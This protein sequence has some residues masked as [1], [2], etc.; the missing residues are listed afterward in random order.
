[1]DPYGL[2]RC[3][4]TCPPNCNLHHTATPPSARP[5]VCPRKIGYY[6]T[7]QKNN[8]EE[9]TRHTRPGTQDQQPISSQRPLHPHTGTKHSKGWLRCPN[10]PPPTAH[11]CTTHAPYTS[12]LSTL[13][14]SRNR[15]TSPRTSHPHQTDSVRCSIPSPKTSRDTKT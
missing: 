2:N 14:P 7:H 4:T 3:T 12:C 10:D 1:M 13:R 11:P 5:R 8:Q 6:N 15:H 9:R